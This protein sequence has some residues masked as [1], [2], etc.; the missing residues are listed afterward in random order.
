MKHASQKTGIWLGPYDKVQLELKLRSIAEAGSE[1]FR[2]L[3]K[4]KGQS[5]PA[6]GSWIKRSD[7]DPTTRIYLGQLASAWLG[8]VA[9]STTPQSGGPHEGAVTPAVSRTQTVWKNS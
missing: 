2:R 7:L 6:P 5:D 3:R 8:R 9:R 1:A 4:L